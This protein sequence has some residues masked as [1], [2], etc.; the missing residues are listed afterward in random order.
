MFAG[1]TVVS[2]VISE[3]VGA[4]SALKMAYAAWSKGSAALLLAVQSAA[5]RAGVADELGETVGTIGR[6]SRWTSHQG[7]A[8]RR[9]E[10]LALGR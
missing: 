3:E 10:G 9:T 5:R 8:L 4:A 2:S 6:P 7:R 1:T